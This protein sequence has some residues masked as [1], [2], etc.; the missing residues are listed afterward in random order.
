MVQNWPKICYGCSRMIYG[1][2]DAVESE[3]GSKVYH[4]ECADKVVASDN[5]ENGLIGE[6]A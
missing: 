3:D 1:E 4:K 2:V 6:V 5:K